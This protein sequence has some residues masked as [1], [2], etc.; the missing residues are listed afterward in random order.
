VIRW[1]VEN[2]LGT[3]AADDVASDGQMVIID[4]RALVDKRGNSATALLAKIDAGVTALTD[5][6]GVVVICDFGVSRSNTIAAGILARWRGLDVD[7]AI[8][9]VVETTGEAS[10]KLEMIESLREAF[11]KPLPDG[12]PSGILITG[13]SGFLGA[14]LRDQ[15]AATGEI[16]APNRAALDLLGPVTL[17]DRYCRENQ[18]GKIVHLAYPRIYTN[19][20]AMGQSLT[21]LRNVLD[22]CKAQGIQLIVSSGW[23]VFSGYRTRFLEADIGTVPRPRGVYGETKYLEELLVG[24][25][26]ANGEVDATIVRLS[27][28]YGANSLRPRLIR[29][30]RQYL[31]EDRTIVTHRYWNGLPRLQLLYIDDAVTGLA[32]IV[33]HGRSPLYHLGGSVAYEPRDIITR[34]GKLIGRKPRI[35]EAPIDD[36]AANIFLNSSATVAELGWKPAIDI[37]DGLRH[38]LVNTE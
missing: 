36:D 1:I 22:V 19:N 38:T 33:K 3:A 21:M 8:A 30:A 17:L 31:L 32:V 25:A 9:Q 11:Q 28:I 14:P 24:N 13:G 29:F 12:R 26:A 16:Y 10:I 27:P 5:G 34:V 15:L 35:D 6:K 7:A 23:V 20:E 2:K 37:D 18:I 4:A